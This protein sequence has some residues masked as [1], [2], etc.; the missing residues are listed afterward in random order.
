[1]PVWKSSL[2]AS[3]TVF[4]LASNLPRSEDYGLCSQIR[5]A[6]NSVSAN[7]AEGFG[8]NG[9]KDKISFYVIA[10]GS[11]FETQ[12]HLLY[13]IKVGYFEESTGLSTIDQYSQ[14]IHDINK[15]IHNIREKLNA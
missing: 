6:A 7:L 4:E 8:R 12:S 11:S 10:R 1:M 13:G 5:R 2:E 14:I 3:K 15:P 9:S